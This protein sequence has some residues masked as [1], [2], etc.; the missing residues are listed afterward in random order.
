MCPNVY[1]LWT[2]VGVDVKQLQSFS[3][4]TAGESEKRLIYYL[5][6]SEREGLLFFSVGVMVCC[7]R[8][9][10]AKRRLSE[11][12]P[13]TDH[14]LLLSVGHLRLGTVCTSWLLG[15]LLRTLLLYD[16]QLHHYIRDTVLPAVWA[17][18]RWEKKIL[19]IFNKNLSTFFPFTSCTNP[20]GP[21]QCQEVME[22]PVTPIGSKF[23]FA[24]PQAKQEDQQSDSTLSWQ[25]E[26][27]THKIWQKDI[28]RIVTDQSS[29][30]PRAGRVFSFEQLCITLKVKTFNAMLV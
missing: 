3:S 27:H 15:V 23:V 14:L 2:V 19:P 4:S 24:P 12:N 13:V 5:A 16:A 8:L 11:S 29:G 17:F 6:N 20:E 25:V 18:I 30:L 21:W 9:C 1:I 22:Q 28:W 10:M 7:Q 26:E